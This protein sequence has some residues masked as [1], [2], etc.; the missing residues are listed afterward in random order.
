MRNGVAALMVKEM[1]MVRQ[2]ENVE[3]FSVDQRQFWRH[4]RNERF[5]AA[6]IEIDVLLRSELFNHV[7][8]GVDGRMRGQL[9][10]NRL[11]DDVLGTNSDGDFRGAESGKSLGVA[12]RD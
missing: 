12:I 4:T 3:W 10:G 11:A 2:N 1:E 9:A 7:D 8:R 5:A 6:D